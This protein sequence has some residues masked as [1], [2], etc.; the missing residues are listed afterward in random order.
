[1]ER[2]GLVNQRETSFW[3]WA[4]RDVSR[5]RNNTRERVTLG[6]IESPDRSFGYERDLAGCARTQAV[7]VENILDK[8]LSFVFSPAEIFGYGFGGLAR[9]GGRACFPS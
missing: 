9:R 1:M 6:Y 8:R 7:A 5:E 3:A 2:S 4:D